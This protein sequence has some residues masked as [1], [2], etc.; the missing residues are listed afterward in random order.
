MQRTIALAIAAIAAAFAHA[1]EPLAV[2]YRHAAWDHYFVS[3]FADEIA[4]LDGGA[5]GGAWKRTGQ[6]FAVRSGPA[7]GAFATCRFFSTAFAPRSSH[8]YTPFAEECAAVKANPNWQFE[9]IAFYLDLPDAS[10][11]CV[12]G[13][14]PLYRLYNDGM[15]A[16]PNHRYT[17]SAATFD[18]M[19]AAGWL[20]EGHGTTHAFACV[21]AATVFGMPEG[22]WIGTTNAGDSVR[23]F[24]LS[25]GTFWF[26]HVPQGATEP[27]GV[28]Q[29]TADAAPGVF[30]SSDARD[31]PVAS[32]GETGTGFS[33]IAIGG[34]YVP[35]TSL[36]LVITDDLGARTLTAS[37]DPSYETPASVAGAAGS[38]SGYSG[39]GDGGVGVNFSVGVD[40]II[41]GAN[42]ICSFRGS[43][44]PSGSGNV[45]TLSLNGISLGCIMGTET[46]IKGF[47]YYDP[48][49]RRFFGLAPFANRTDSYHLV[50]GKR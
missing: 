14:A 3:A 31:F 7:A 2:E 23:G 47:A 22:M 29:G 35:R 40:G 6:T 15:G 5:F 18:E 21:P 1:Q 10:G 50:A 30:K 4:A 45:F 12:S 25:D 37:Y 24:V 13:T 44:A 26:V 9:A 34:T 43:I 17:T 46:A 33:P 38:Y 19:L 32:T 42:P 20:A 8:F 11:A 16:A 48:S 36:S 28:W 39:H 27:S 49:S 41:S